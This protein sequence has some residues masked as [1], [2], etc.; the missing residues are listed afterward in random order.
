MDLLEEEDRI[1]RKNC[2]Q[3]HKLFFQD[4]IKWKQRSRIR[5]LEARDWNTKYFHAIANARCHVNRINAISANGRVWEKREDI[6][7]EVVHFFQ[8]LY[9]GDKRSRAQMDD[10]SFKNLFSSLERHFCKKEIKE[11][12]FDLGSDHSSGL[13][14]FHINFSQ[15]FWDMIEDDL[16]VFFNELHESGVIVGELGAS[17]I[18]LIPKKDGA[19]SIKAYMPI[20]LIG[21]LYK[22]LAEV[23]ANWL[24]KVLLEIISELQGA[25]VDGRQILGSVFIAH[26]LILGIAKSVLV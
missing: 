14:Y 17:F 1:N 21:S 13:D 10:I 23:P 5:Q 7:R 2:Q 25:F 8:Q 6:E 11:A 24:R 19:A 22:I 16:L 18:S 3:F 12:V 4:E 9:T 20:S 15:H 26:V